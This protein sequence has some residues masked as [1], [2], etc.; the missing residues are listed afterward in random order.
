METSVL[1]VFSTMT[2]DP[3]HWKIF[4]EGR[5][6]QVPLFN[7]KFTFPSKINTVPRT[8]HFPSPPTNDPGFGLKNPTPCIFFFWSIFILF[9]QEVETPNHYCVKFSS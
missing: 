4:C 2:G 8:V 6:F 1:T 7:L 5:F 3:I 9:V